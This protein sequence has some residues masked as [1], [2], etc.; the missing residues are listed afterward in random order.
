MLK[1]VCGAAKSAAMAAGIAATIGFAGAAAA[2]LEISRISQ[3][4]SYDPKTLHTGPVLTYVYG[5]PVRDILPRELVANLP[6]PEQL[7]PVRFT[8]GDNANHETNGARLILVF[9][10]A[11]PSA[12]EIC[13]DPTKIH[14][15][16][17]D[18]ELDVFA[19][20]C[21]DT[22]WVAQGHANNVAVHSGK[23][24]N[25]LAAMKALFTEMFPAKTP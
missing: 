25:Y 19:A 22:D 10:S 13:A 24:P 17:L 12:G 7:P 15:T 8:L 1:S 6:G 20:Y 9:N 16:V 2:S 18:V 3:S 5:S 4:E 21:I 14:S 11:L 23:D